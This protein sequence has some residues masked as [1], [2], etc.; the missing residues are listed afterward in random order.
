MALDFKYQ[1]M[2]HWIN[3]YKKRMKQQKHLF[4]C[5]R[6]SKGPYKKLRLKKV[7]K[8]ESVVFIYLVFDPPC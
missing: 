3:K 4:Y 8:Q 5:A 2:F 7:A 1:Q 6:S